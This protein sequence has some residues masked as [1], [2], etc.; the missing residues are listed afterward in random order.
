MSL[1]TLQFAI[2]ENLANETYYETVVQ[3]VCRRLHFHCN[4]TVVHFDFAESPNP[5]H[6]FTHMIFHGNRTYDFG[7]AGFGITADRM[8]TVKFIFPS[9]GTKYVLAVYA[10]NLAPPGEGAFISTLFTRIPAIETF[11]VLTLV[12]LLLALLITCAKFVAKP[13]PRAG[14]SL[15]QRLS[16]MTHSMFRLY[17]VAFGQDE[18]VLRWTT[19]TSL[20]TLNAIWFI[21]A[22]IIGAVFCAI[23]PSLLTVATNQLP[24]TDAHSFQQSGFALVGGGLAFQLLNES[25]DPM[26]QS[27]A[28]SMH[29][30]PYNQVYECASRED[31]S[32]RQASQRVAYIRE[33]GGL[34]H[35]SPN[36]STSI[37]AVPSIAQIFATDFVTP[38]DSQYWNNF[39]REYLVLQEHGLLQ[40]LDVLSYYNSESSPHVTL[41]ERER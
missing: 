18:I 21:V 14:Y 35:P 30:V 34:S 3:L 41:Q 28:R 26:R 37:A 33:A 22:T 2:H 23:I 10:E 4:V 9:M 39:S 5:F 17:T 20:Y 31:R 8:E 11:G 40:H 32:I 38:K 24:F 1:K 19:P 6:G 29:V 36:C 12:Y 27:I 25:S 13:T 7:I 15:F 16:K